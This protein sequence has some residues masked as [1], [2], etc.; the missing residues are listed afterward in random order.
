MISITRMLE[1]NASASVLVLNDRV[2]FRHQLPFWKIQLD[3]DKIDIGNLQLRVLM[4]EWY[5][6]LFH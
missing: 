6:E 5:G 4:E 1:C 3:V 2:F